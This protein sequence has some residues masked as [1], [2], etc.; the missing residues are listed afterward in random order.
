MKNEKF[1]RYSELVFSGIF[2][3][4]IF[5]FFMFFYNS[6]LHFAEQFQL[7]LL[8]G[9][10]FTTRIAF[11]GGF[12]GWLGDFLTQFYYLSFAGP[13]IIA[14]LLL[15]LQLVI[16]RML[17]VINPDPLLFPVSFLPSLLAG[18]ILC[19]EFYPLSSITGFLIAMGAG[20]IYLRITGQTRRFITGLVLIPLVYWL[21]GGSYLS[22]LL[23]IFLHELLLWRKSGKGEEVSK[24]G[25]GTFSRWLYFPAL[26]I[27]SAGIP[28][29]VR[30]FLIQ[31]PIMLTYITEYYYNL[32][33][34]L[35][36]A[37]F[38][39]FILPPVLMIAVNLAVIRE[40]HM[41]PALAVQA[42]VFALLAFFGFRSFANFEA[43]Q[44]MTYDY[45]VKNERWKDVIKYAEKKPPKN[46]LSLSML[47]LSLAKTGE[48]G[49]SMFKYNQH[50]VNGLFLAFNRE[51]V[52]ALMGSEI[53]YHLSLTNASQE[54]AFESMQ[55]VPDMGQSVRVIKRLAETNLINGQYKVSEKYLGLLENTLF[56]RKWAKNT[57]T[58]LGNEE[59]INSHP[60]W[61][62]KR[63][64]SVRGDYFFHIKNIEAVL[65]R[66]V[67]ENPGNRVAFEYLMAF[68]MINKD[69]RNFVNLIP[70]MEK[71]QY[72]T[73]PVSYQEA[74]MYIVGLNSEDPVN[75]AP[76]YISRETKTRMMAYAD[77]YTSRPDAETRLSEKYAATY[78]YYLHFRDA[79]LSQVEETKDNTGST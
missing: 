67:K 69:L 23:V 29:L 28:F 39:L 47:N 1:I 60:D 53:L 72:K 42:G 15:V 55:T 57:M 68:Y 14:G 38:L 79:E 2:F 22:L 41:K 71:M 31:Q 8:T 36:S 40:K 66:M 27:L 77:I 76:S 62:E 25:N 70:V 51:Y 49:N 63:K 37:V 56:Y 20:L 19:N 16:R 7:F 6:H 17:A 34:T 65:N 54:Y 73:V 9:D 75:D 4:G 45:L 78:W 61:G 11:P 43:E 48:L 3:A 18:M 21:A 5:I 74:I 12:N 10:Y 50:G 13:L 59:K 32:R 24:A 30:Q 35:P 52:T 44:I 58:Y 26:I 33:T 46:Y 64:F